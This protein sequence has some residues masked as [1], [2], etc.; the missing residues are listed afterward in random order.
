[1]RHPEAVRAVAAERL[2]GTRL[3]FPD[4]PL[5]GRAWQAFHTHIVSQR[6]TGLLSSAV[7]H[8][9]LPVT[10]EQQQLLA[11]LDAAQSTVTLMLDRALLETV[12]CLDAN[13]IEVRVLKGASFAHTAYPDP[14]LRT[15]GDVDVLVRSDQ[16]DAAL[17]ALLER[18]GQR[19]FLEPRPGFLRRFGKGV[20]I[21]RPDGLDVDLHRTLA[22]G[23]FGLAIDLP[24]LF[25]DTTSFELGG[26]TLAGLGGTARFLHACFHAVLGSDPPRLLPLRDVAQLALHAPLDA[27]DVLTTAERWRATSIVA[28]ALETTWRELDVADVIPLSTWAANHEPNARDLR[29]LRVYRNDGRRYPRQAIATLRSIPRLADRFAYARAMLFPDRA[30]LREHDGSYA[31]RARRSVSVLRDVAS[32]R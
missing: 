2:P 13:G 32:E 7:V 15:Y 23:P 3:S 17:D 20:S 18:G 8:G 12:D 5:T 1:M 19:R 21:R 27:A 26:R 29:Q 16:F 6:L 24:A 11:D 25:E 31:R 4:E 22:P 30:Y 9:R 10:E 28:L 14:A